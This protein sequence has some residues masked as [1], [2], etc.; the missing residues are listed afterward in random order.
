[1][2]VN[3][4]LLAARL[5]AS[6]ERLRAAL[7]SAQPA[8]GTSAEG[9]TAAAQ[10]ADLLLG[11]LRT[12]WTRHP[13]VLVGLSALGGALLVWSRPWRW[14][15]SPLL[16]AGLLPRL[17]VKAMSQVSAPVWMALLAALFKPGPKE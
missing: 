15:L 16:V 4:R 14:L 9:Q 8:A 17:I 12:W 2:N 13:W 1:M 5:E 10:A 6:R 3:D 7:R 11:A